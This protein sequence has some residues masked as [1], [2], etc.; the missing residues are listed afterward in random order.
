MTPM[1]DAAAPP[2]RP[3]PSPARRPD[4]APA[5]VVSLVEHGDSYLRD[6]DVATA[7]VLYGRAADAGDGMAALRM[8]ATYD[9]AFLGRGALRDVR[10]DPAEARS[11][12]RRARDLGVAE[13]DLRL[14]RLEPK[15]AR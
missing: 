1:L 13:A 10:G 14:K 4:A 11:W 7:R 8:G 3:P 12:Y 2:P 6:G 5:E 15:P 9:P